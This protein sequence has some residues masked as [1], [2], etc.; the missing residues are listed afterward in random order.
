M[1]VCVLLLWC[2]THPVLW[3]SIHTF[4]RP[5]ISFC[6]TQTHAASQRGRRVNPHTQRILLPLYA[7]PSLSAPAEILP[8]SLLTAALSLHPSA[9]HSGCKKLPTSSSS[10]SLPLSGFSLLLSVHTPSISQRS[11]GKALTV[12]INTYSKQM[13]TRTADSLD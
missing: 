7:F 12:F 8:A 3:R 9:N 6:H 13:H 11:T 5:L 4:S 1:C 10:S 2:Q